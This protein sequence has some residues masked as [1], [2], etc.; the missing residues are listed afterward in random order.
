[1]EGSEESGSEYT[2]SGGEEQDE[3]GILISQSR[4]KRTSAARRRIRNAARRRIMTQEERLEEERA[5]QEAFDATLLKLQEVDRQIER[6]TELE[7]DSISEYL[8]LEWIDLAS[9]LLD[10][11]R[12][13]KALFPSDGKKRYFATSRPFRRKKKGNGQLEEEEN[14]DEQA[15]GIAERLHAS[16]QDEEN[17]MID[18]PDMNVE[19]DS[20]RGV[21]FD[22]WALLTVR[23]RHWMLVFT[24][25]QH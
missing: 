14:V 19:Q 20:Y 24:A 23:V 10:N 3:Y 8:Q 1:M 9:H 25:P 4:K 16:L 7:S 5:V 6:E 12:T 21:S 11:F 18:E 17:S 13:T 22:D 15:A 2:M